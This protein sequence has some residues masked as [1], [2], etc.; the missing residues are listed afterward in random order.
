MI[1]RASDGE[2]GVGDK[3]GM[4]GD[5]LQAQTIS[6][7]KMDIRVIKQLNQNGKH[8]Y[9]VSCLLRFYHPTTRTFPP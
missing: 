9:I 6:L 2:E 4:Q 3:L 8:V 1:R 5:N 7:H